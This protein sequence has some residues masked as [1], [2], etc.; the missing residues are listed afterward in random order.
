MNIGKIR[1]LASFYGLV[2]GFVIGDLF[3]YTL[4]F[5]SL[6]VIVGFFVPL[7]FKKTNKKKL[8]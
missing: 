5:V 6:G 7:L 2:F 3:G 1:I 8:Y 4:L